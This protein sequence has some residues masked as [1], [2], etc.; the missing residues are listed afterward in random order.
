MTKKQLRQ[1]Y[2]A[3][4]RQLTQPVYEDMNRLLLQQFQKLD[5]TGIQC[6]HMFL[7][8]QERRE[9]DTCLIRNWL[10]SGHPQIMRVFPK[11]DFTDCTMRSYADDQHLQTAVNPMGIPEP[12]AGTPIDDTQIDLIIVP[13]LAFD[14]QGYRVGYGKGFYDRFIACCRPNVQLTGLSFFPPVDHID[15]LHEFDQPLHQCITPDGI[16]YF[17]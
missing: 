8:A 13:L 14:R 17:K 2:T 1:L 15:D 10:R 11:A 5:L 7:P 16:W 6:I 12:V 4:R 9:P 3:R